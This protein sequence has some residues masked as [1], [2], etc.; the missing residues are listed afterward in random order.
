MVH[1]RLIEHDPEKWEP[2]FGIRSCSRKKIERVDDPKEVILL[3]PLSGD[4]GTG[5]RQPAAANDGL[6]G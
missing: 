2:V 5:W 3:G 4:V 6:T 1:D